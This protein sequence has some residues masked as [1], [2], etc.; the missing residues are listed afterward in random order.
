LIL[1]SH[2][3]R[4]HLPNR[5]F[6]SLCSIDPEGSTTPRSSVLESLQAEAQKAGATGTPSFVLAETDPA[7][8]TKVKGVSFIRGAQAFNGFNAA[9]DGAL[10]E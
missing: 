6:V 4:T 7:D 2:R 1:W 3:K 8:P 9:I 10:A 5:V